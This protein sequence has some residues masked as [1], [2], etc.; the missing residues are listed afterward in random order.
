MMDGPSGA[1]SVNRRQTRD[2]SP[3]ICCTS[4]HDFDKRR[5]GNSSRPAGHAH[6]GLLDALLLTVPS[7]QKLAD[8]LA[9]LVRRYVA[10]DRSSL[11][12]TLFRSR[13]AAA[14]AAPG[15]RS[16]LDRNR[17]TLLLSAPRF[18]PLFCPPGCIF[19]SAEPKHAGIMIRVSGVRVPPPAS[20]L[21]AE[22]A[23]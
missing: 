20:T 2:R 18:C 21:D 5:V 15:S 7:T 11:A 22:S 14:H 4:C 17:G 6:V 13:A 9:P 12:C 23:L 16:C 3:S 8:A 19:G 10:G 1:V